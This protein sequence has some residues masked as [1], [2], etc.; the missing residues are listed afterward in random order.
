M[1]VALQEGQ[2]FVQEL[3]GLFVE[4][5]MARAANDYMLGPRDILSYMGPVLWRYEAVALAPD[6]QGGEREALEAGLGYAAGPQYV[7]AL[8]DGP[9]FECYPGKRGVEP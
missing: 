1:S 5:H 8:R 4:R 3:A 9:A 7:Q 6:Y 2:D